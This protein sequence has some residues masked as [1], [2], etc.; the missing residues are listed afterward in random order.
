M[1]GT[2]RLYKQVI[3]GKAGRLVFD[4]VDFDGSKKR[5]VRQFLP[6]QRLL[7]LG[8]GHIAFELCRL[9]SE[10]DFQ[11]TVV[12]DRREFASRERFP[13]ASRV[14]CGDF[15]K[16]IGELEITAFDYVA[17]MTRGH[18]ADGVCLKRVLRGTKPWYL[19]M[20]GSRRKTAL[21]RE[22]LLEEGFS[23]EQLDQVHAPIGLE[24]GARTPAEI[25]ISI[26]A[27]LIQARSH[28]INKEEGLLDYCNSDMNLLK[29]MEKTTSPYMLAVVL[30]KCGSAPVAGGA[31]MAVTHAGIAAGTIGGGRG[32]LEVIQEARRFL[33]TGESRMVEVNMTG[34]DAAGQKMICGGTLKVWLEY[35][36]GQTDETKCGY[37]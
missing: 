23:E 27:Q 31:I 4:V 36:G 10:L 22:A 29:F 16:I 35:C 17:I 34:Q 8:G 14:V 26:L 2:K 33:E 12:D 19:G 15:E 7:L 18:L 20:V 3:G 37:Q 21:L 13:Q 11:V 32:E 6:H 1:E 25:A 5:F 30:E 24:I 28:Q 9:A